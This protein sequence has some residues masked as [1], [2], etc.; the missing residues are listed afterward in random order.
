[1]RRDAATIRDALEFLVDGLFNKI[2][3]FVDDERPLPRVLAEIQAQLARDDHL[4][5]HSA[6]HRLLGRCRNRLIKCIRMQAVAVIEQCIERLQRGANVVK[7]DL[8]RVQASARRLDVVLEHLRAGTCTVTLAHC[9]CPDAPR[10]ATDDGV[11]GIHPIRKEEAQVRRKVVDAHAASQVVLDDCESVRQGKRK[12]T[13]RVR[14]G[15][16]DMVTADRNAVVIADVVVDEK[17][18]DVAHHL[19]RELGREDTGVLRL[20]FL[21]NVGLYGASHR[22]QCFLA[23]SGI[24]FCIDELVAGDSQQTRDP[25]RHYLQA[26]RRRNVAAPGP[27]STDRSSS[28]QPPTGPSHAGVF[29]PAGR[30][31]YS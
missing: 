15:F 3:Q 31:R 25:G 23:D 27:R 20:V 5:C 7:T 29:R 26:I 10:H 2:C 21:E 22:C 17:L 8:L 12:L 18:L 14:P 24:G 6:P 13:D 1:M 30:W 11:F 4:D 9:P 19:H 16:G 28:A